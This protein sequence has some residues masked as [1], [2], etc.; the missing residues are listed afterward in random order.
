MAGII[1]LANTAYGKK[2]NRLGHTGIRS[3]LSVSVFGNHSYFWG[4][5]KHIVIMISG[6]RYLG[7]TTLEVSVA[8]MSKLGDVPR[9]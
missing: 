5:G 3:R 4:Y 9:P 8:T 1:V 2:R 7:N 6:G